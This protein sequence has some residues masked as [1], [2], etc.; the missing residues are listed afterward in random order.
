MRITATFVNCLCL[1]AGRRRRFHRACA[2]LVMLT[3]LEA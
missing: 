1:E 2:A 3:W